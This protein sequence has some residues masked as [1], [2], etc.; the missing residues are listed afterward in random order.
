[1]RP[2]MSSQEH[3]YRQPEGFYE[4]RTLAGSTTYQMNFYDLGPDVQEAAKTA[5]IIFREETGTPSTDPADYPFT[6]DLP[7][8]ALGITFRLTINMQM[9]DGEAF[10]SDNISIVEAAGD[11]DYEAGWVSPKIEVNG[12]TYVFRIDSTFSTNTRTPQDRPPVAY[13]TPA[14]GVVAADIL[15]NLVDLINQTKQ[16]NVPG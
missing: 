5:S 3:A 9:L 16:P 4:I 12:F 6:Q 15:D 11:G 1:M 14:N 8:P 2:T 7:N 10:Y 13:T